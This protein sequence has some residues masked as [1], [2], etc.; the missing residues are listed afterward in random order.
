MS[1]AAPSDNDDADNVDVQQL[2]ASLGSNVRKLFHSARH[3]AS[4]A[5]AHPSS[6]AGPGAQSGT[7]TA[8][9]RRAEQ[10]VVEL[11]ASRASTSQLRSLVILQQKRAY[12]RAAGYHAA[13]EL[14]RVSEGNPRL[15]CKLL[16]DLV[17]VLKPSA[18]D[19]E[20]GGGAVGLTRHYSRD[21]QCAGPHAFRRLRLAFA[22]LL[23]Q[24]VRLAADDGG[25]AGT[26]GGRALL[27]AAAAEGVEKDRAHSFRF[28]RCGRCAACFTR[29]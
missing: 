24:L 3:A 12:S 26:A 27:L 20:E 23:G 8:A 18:A 1:A 25:A 2:G 10:D 13:C 5:F 11:V 21:L 29:S 9:G 19:E 16:A 28:T 17:A 15:Q 7:W 22:A 4:P 14:L 6:S